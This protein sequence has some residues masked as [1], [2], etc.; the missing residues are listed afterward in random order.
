MADE[1]EQQTRRGPGRPRQA[2]VTRAVL[3]AVVDLV[4]ENGMNALTM[5]AVA[6]RAG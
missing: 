3:D 5:D 2:H 1:Q 4:A 6:A